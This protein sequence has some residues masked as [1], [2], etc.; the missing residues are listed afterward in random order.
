VVSKKLFF[1]NGNNLRR[2]AT[3]RFFVKIFILFNYKTYNF[4]FLS[5]S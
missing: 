4:V 5:G 2:V 1:V 3:N